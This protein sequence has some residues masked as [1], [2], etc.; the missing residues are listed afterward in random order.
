MFGDRLGCDRDCLC[1]RAFAHASASLF[2]MCLCLCPIFVHTQLPCGWGMC[3]LF[4]ALSMLTTLSVCPDPGA[5]EQ[6]MEL[7]KQ[8]LEAFAA[9]DAA[10]EVE[11]SFV[12]V[13]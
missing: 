7:G 11:F 8:E 5:Y 13:V 12:L 1:I 10:T 2:A 3:T 6:L 9:Q 4:Q